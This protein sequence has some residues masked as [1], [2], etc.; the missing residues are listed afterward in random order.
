M[1]TTLRA[2]RSGRSTLGPRVWRPARGSAS[3]G[4]FPGTSGPPT[5]GWGHDAWR[6]ILA[7]VVRQIDH[8]PEHQ[9]GHHHGDE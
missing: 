8:D 1:A 5:A 2:E 7:D 3:C 9:H 6:E 4:S